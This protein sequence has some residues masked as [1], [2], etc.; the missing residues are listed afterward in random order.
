M[1]KLKMVVYIDPGTCAG[2]TGELLQDLSNHRLCSKNQRPCNTGLKNQEENTE[3]VNKY[4][5]E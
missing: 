4:K 1:Y 3:I 5:T 2:G